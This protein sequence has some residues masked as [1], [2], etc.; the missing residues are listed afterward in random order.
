MPASALPTGVV[1]IVATRTAV[2]AIDTVMRTPIAHILTI[3][4]VIP[5][6]IA[7]ALVTVQRGV[8]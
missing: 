3:G 4:T 7:R 2:I 1:A 6:V 5:I 8:V